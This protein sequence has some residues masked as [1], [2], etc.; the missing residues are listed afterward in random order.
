MLHKPLYLPQS[1]KYRSDD[2]L[3][4]G[5]VLSGVSDVVDAVVL[6]AADVAGDVVAVD[7]AVRVTGGHGKA[8]HVQLE[9]IKS[10]RCYFP[11]SDLRFTRLGMGCVLPKYMVRP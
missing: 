8:E 1:L 5:P 4:I 3:I 2:L 10:C 6:L 9:T 7:D 11:M